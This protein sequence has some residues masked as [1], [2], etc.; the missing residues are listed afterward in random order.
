M[1]NFLAFAT[2]T[3]A[4]R[5]N[6]Q[7]AVSAD[8]PGASVSTQRPDASR[9]SG[10]S[11]QLNIYLYQITPN[12][13]WRNNDLP[14]RNCDGITVQR[15][16]TGFDLHYLLSFYGDEGELE[17]QRL[18]GSTVRKLHERPIITRQQI[19]RTTTDKTFFYLR[20][21]N[22]ADEDESIKFTPNPMSLEE[23]SKLW[24]VFFQTAYALSIA[25]SGT[26]VL[27]DGSGIPKSSLPVRARNI[28]IGPLIGASQRPII[29]SILPEGGEDQPILADSRIIIRGRY[30]AGENIRVRIGGVEIAPAQV[31]DSEIVINLNDIAGDPLRAGA[32]NV[33]VVR[34]QMLGTPPVL[35]PVMESVPITIVIR[36]VITQVSGPTPVRRR[37]SRKKP[38]GN[39]QPPSISIEL[40]PMAGSK[41]RLALMLNHIA[42][43]ETTAYTLW[44]PLRDNDSDQLEFPV[45]DLEPG[46]YLVAVQVDG[47]ES[48]HDLDMDPDSPTYHQFTGPMVTIP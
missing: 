13:T 20:D 16:R 15:P 1:S 4:L 31:S 27:I 45:D 36:P 19:E 43:N 40:K 29:D 34:M 47:I 12:T 6:L 41:Q 26:V 14:T 39:F 22:L 35:H 11:P 37:G 5:Q 23:L 9:L 33:Q 17:P 32:Q 18:L 8:V 44:A 28:V 7:E 2:V 25:Y 21:S 24:S 42:D 3:A 10:S 38:P 48:V 30:L 46:E